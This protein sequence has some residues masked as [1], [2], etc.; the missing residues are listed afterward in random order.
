MRFC[1]R[2][3]QDVRDAI[4]KDLHAAL[5][6]AKQHIRGAR[7]DALKAYTGAVGKAADKKDP[8]HRDVSRSGPLA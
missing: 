5:E 1:Y 8:F 7:T 2:P 6:T 4:T 3:T